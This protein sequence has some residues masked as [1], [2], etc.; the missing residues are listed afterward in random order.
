MQKLV[1]QRILRRRKISQKFLR[2]E[3]VPRADQ[4]L[5]S[6]RPRAPFCQRSLADRVTLNNRNDKRT[7]E[8][9]VSLWRLAYT[10]STRGDHLKNVWLVLSD[11]PSVEMKKIRCLRASKTLYWKFKGIE[12]V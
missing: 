11:R 3:R 1:S 5:Q 2:G 4:T 7:K 10:D 12:S 8:N 9:G 6:G